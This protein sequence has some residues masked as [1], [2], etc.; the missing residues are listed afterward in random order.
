MGYTKPQLC[1][2]EHG[3]H[4]QLDDRDCLY[5]KSITRIVVANG[6]AVSIGTCLLIPVL[7]QKRGLALRDG[8]VLAKEI[9]LRLEI[10]VDALVV[11]QLIDL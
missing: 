7:W 3:W 6:L 5:R 2:I 1:E 4:L 11:L 10:E 9:N 8:L